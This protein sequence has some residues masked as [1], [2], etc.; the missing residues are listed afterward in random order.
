MSDL[1]EQLIERILRAQT[2]QAEEQL[3]QIFPRPLPREKTG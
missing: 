3:L 1:S 2:S